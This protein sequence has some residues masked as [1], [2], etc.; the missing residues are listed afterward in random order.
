MNEMISSNMID[1]TSWWKFANFSKS[2]SCPKT[3]RIKNVY[4]VANNFIA[5]LKKK[6][7]KWAMHDFIQ[8]FRNVY[9]FIMESLLNVTV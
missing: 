9:F 3:H 2:K 6:N 8:S 1:L 7:R 4:K 5:L